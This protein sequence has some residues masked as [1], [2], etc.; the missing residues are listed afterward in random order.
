ML[1]Q[2]RLQKLNAFIEKAIGYGGL[3]KMDAV[4]LQ[5]EKYNHLTTADKIKWLEKACNNAVYSGQYEVIEL[6]KE[7]QETYLFQ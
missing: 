5:S 2:I 3:L 6:E 7:I 4:A 1:E